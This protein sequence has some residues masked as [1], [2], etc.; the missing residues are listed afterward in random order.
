MI[1][2]TI[3][4]LKPSEDNDLLTQYDMTRY[5]LLDHDQST[6]VYHFLDF[7]AEQDEFVDAVAADEAITSYWHEFG[8]DSDD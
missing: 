2:F 7:M 3:Y 5:R 1:D 4:S 8:P 6:A